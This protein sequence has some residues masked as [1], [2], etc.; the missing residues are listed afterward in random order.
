MK[1]QNGSKTS[2]TRLSG[3]AFCAAILLAAT[4]LVGCTGAAGEKDAVAELES[5]GAVVMDKD[6]RAS[7]AVLSTT[8]AKVVDLAVAIPLLKKLGKLE[9]LVLNGTT[10]TDEQLQIVGELSSLGDLQLSDTPI[11]DAGITHLTGLSNLTSIYVSNTKVTD[12]SMSEFAKLSKLSTLGI[13]GTQI[14]GGFGALSALENLVLLVAGELTITDEELA[15][16]ANIPNLK[17]ADLTGATVNEAAVADLR[18]N[19]KEVRF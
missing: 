8:T 15:K 1:F 17:R 4:M 10:V 7:T 19:V 6:G 11:T 14:T 9:S 13:N 18:K 2:S 5:L 3:Y 12:A 16:I